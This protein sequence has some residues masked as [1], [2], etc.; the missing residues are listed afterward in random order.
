MCVG[1]RWGLTKGSAC[2]I[3]Y[4]LILDQPWTS[5]EDY[6]T[7]TDSLATPGSLFNQVCPSAD[8]PF[9]SMYAMAVQKIYYAFET[10]ASGIRN[11]QTRDTMGPTILFTKAQ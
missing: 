3:L 7:E 1:G 10:V 8:L 2:V 6:L 9:K 5:W 4:D 11:L